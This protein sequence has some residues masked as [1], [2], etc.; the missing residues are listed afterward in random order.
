MIAGSCIKLMPGFIA[1]NGCY[2]KAYISIYGCP[3]EATDPILLTV[4]DDAGIVDALEI[5]LY[6]NPTS[7]YLTIEFNTSVN[8]NNK[9]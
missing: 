2:F 1:Y 4:Q 9:Y 5:N 7:G 3:G 6:P 8:D